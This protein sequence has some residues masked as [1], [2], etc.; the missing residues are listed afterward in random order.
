MSLSQ[1]H[2]MQ[3]VFFHPAK[4]GRPHK[5]IDRDAVRKVLLSALEGHEGSP[6]EPKRGSLEPGQTVSFDSI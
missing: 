1:A 4:G 2:T 3:P 6:K 5:E